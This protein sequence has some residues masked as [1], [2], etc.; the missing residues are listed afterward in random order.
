MQESAFELGHVHYLVVVLEMNL[1]YRSLRPAIVIDSPWAMLACIVE[2]HATNDSLPYRT[3]LCLIY[4][5]TTAHYIRRLA[6]CGVRI[7][8]KCAKPLD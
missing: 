4:P 1:A 7:G 2:T 8:S 6:D 5:F 3:E